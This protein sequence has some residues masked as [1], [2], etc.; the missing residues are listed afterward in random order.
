MYEESNSR[1]SIGEDGFYYQND[2]GEKVLCYG[3]FY[4]KI[5]LPKV[6]DLR[7]IP[8]LPTRGPK[9]KSYVSRTFLHNLFTFQFVY[10]FTYLI[11]RLLLASPVLIK[12]T[13]E[14]ALMTLNREVLLKHT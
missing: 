7:G 8:F 13:R 3:V 9:G 2:D 10:L 12:S 6:N 1:L 14:Y 4:V 5:A 11:C